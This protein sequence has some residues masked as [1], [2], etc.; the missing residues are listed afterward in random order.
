ML[1]VMKKT[2]SAPTSDAVG[3]ESSVGLFSSVL[4]WSR[5]FCCW[6]RKPPPVFSFINQH[7]RGGQEEKEERLLLLET[8][9]EKSQIREGI[10]NICLD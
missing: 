5:D 2:L 8:K 7:S 3:S 10:K 1:P 6:A 4:M 9:S